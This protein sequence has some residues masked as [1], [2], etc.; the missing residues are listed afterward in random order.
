MRYLTYWLLPFAAAAMA[1]AAAYIAVRF[2]HPAVH[3]L[4]CKQGAVV[5]DVDHVRNL[6]AIGSEIS[7]NI[8]ASCGLVLHQESVGGAGSG[9]APDQTSSPR[10]PLTIWPDRLPFRSPVK[11]TSNEADV[12]EKKGCLA[13]MYSDGWMDGWMDR[14][15]DM[16]ASGRRRSPFHKIIATI[17]YTL[18]VPERIQTST[19]PCAPAC[20]ERHT[21]DDSN[22][23]SSSTVPQCFTGTWASMFEEVMRFE[24]KVENPR[25]RQLFAR[26]PCMNKRDSDTG[27]KSSNPVLQNLRYHGECKLRQQGASKEVGGWGAG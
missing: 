5:L 10:K 9:L 27:M 24:T 13:D 12:N 20:A 26:S 1:L 4:H 8:V 7:T 23:H 25:H 3:N 22:G 19:S 14:W 6:K 15:A 17:S 2:T 11:T 18:A 21:I 16:N